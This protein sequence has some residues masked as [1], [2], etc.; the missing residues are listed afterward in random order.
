MTTFAAPI[1]PP[2]APGSV[3]LPVVGVARAARDATLAALVVLCAT[4]LAW[5]EMALQDWIPAELDFPAD[6][7]VV[8]DR[9]I[10]STV[11]MFSVAT[12]EETGPLLERW[13][14]ALRTSGYAIER[15]SEELVEGSIEFSG[16]GIANAKIVANRVAEDGQT[17]IEFDATLD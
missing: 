8:T 17:L 13:E 1:A 4:A 3:R 5:A 16:P 10:G 11:R 2:F 12:G 7:Q 15:E 6:A 14:E 9:E